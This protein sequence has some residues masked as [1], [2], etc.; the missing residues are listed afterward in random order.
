MHVHMKETKKGSPD[1]IEVREY[2]A[3]ESY[4]MPEQLGVVFVKEGWGEEKPMEE[5]KSLKGPEETKVDGPKEKK[6]AV[7]KG[8]AKAAEESIFNEGPKA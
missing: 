1:G 3:G 8:K 2:L 4:E 5:N 6:P 7:K